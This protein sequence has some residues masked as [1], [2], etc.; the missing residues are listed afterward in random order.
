MNNNKA[1]QYGNPRREKGGGEKSLTI[2]EKNELGCAIRQLNP[3][4]LRGIISLLSDTL[5]TEQS[6][7]YF[8]FDIESLPTRKLRELEKYV[9]NC[10]RNGNSRNNN[11]NENEKI[12][13]LKV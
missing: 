1:L 4:Q 5:N 7:K 2:Q 11:L 12:E 13:K 3:E 9:M 6:T 10:S 8:E